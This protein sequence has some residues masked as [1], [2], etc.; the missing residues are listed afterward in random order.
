MPTYIYFHFAFSFLFFILEEE[1]TFS[2]NW[3]LLADILMSIILNKRF[4]FS[5][6]KLEVRSIFNTGLHQTISFSI[7]YFYLRAC[8]KV[9]IKLINLSTIF[10]YMR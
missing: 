7:A 5:N 2:F 3:P 8:L 4:S 1:F 6:L 9:R 10:F